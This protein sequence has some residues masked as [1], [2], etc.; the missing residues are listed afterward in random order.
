M[1]VHLII[2]DNDHVNV[3]SSSQSGEASKVLIWRSRWCFSLKTK[4]YTGAL[5][6]SNKR[7]STDCYHWIALM[8]DQVRSYVHNVLLCQSNIVVS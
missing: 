7:W 1:L 8:S 2:L 5:G 3:V 6:L 4:C